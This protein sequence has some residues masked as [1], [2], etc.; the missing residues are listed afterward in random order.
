M[1]PLRQKS[2]APGSAPLRQ[3]FVLRAPLQKNLAPLR[4]VQNSMLHAPLR[5]KLLALAP[6]LLRSAEPLR[7]LRSV[8]SEIRILSL[9]RSK[10]LALFGSAPKILAPLRQ[11]YMAP[12]SPPLRQILVLLSEKFG[13]APLRPKYCAIY[14]APLRPNLLAPA[15][16]RLR[17]GSAPAPLRGAAPCAPLGANFEDP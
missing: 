6:L 14:S 1:P 3:I 7:G 2:M 4:S 11:K 5:P 17:S 12:C 16:L 9:L 15:P 13:S 8:S 10:I